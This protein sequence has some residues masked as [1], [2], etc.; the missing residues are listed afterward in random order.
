MA[1]LDHRSRYV[2][3]SPS[4]LRLDDVEGRLDRDKGHS[5]GVRI[6]LTQTASHAIPKYLSARV[7]D[8]MRRLDRAS[9][10]GTVNC[11]DSLPGS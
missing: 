4:K 11:P 1:P 7:F 3:I 9:S 2:R 10:L 8:A 5:L 6:S